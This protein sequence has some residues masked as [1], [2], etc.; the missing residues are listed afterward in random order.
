MT[1]TSYHVRHPR[2]SASVEFALLLPIFFTLIAGIWEVARLVQLQEILTSAAREGGRQAATG[3]MTNSSVQNVVYNHLNNEGIQVTDTNGN[4][5]S[6]VAV[7]VTNNTETGV[8]AAQAAKLDSLTVS[9]TIPFSLVQ[10]SNLNY[11]V[12][13]NS[14]IDASV[15]WYSMNN[16]AFTVDQSIPTIPK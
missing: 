14:T 9:V 16:A 4:P 10:W 13:A 6:G 2:A 3:T 11:F 1:R 8:D 15:V 12:T 5:L 7:T